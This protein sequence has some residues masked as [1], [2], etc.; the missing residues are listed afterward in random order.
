MSVEATGVIESTIN[1][2][3]TGRIKLLTGVAPSYL[4]QEDATLILQEDGESRIVLA[5]VDV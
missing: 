3:T 2:V 4:L 5:G 1:F